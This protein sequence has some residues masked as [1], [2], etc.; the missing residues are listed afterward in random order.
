MV[1]D[2][3][4]PAARARKPPLNAGLAPHQADPPHVPQSDRASYR[5]PKRE[6][7]DAHLGL[8]LGGPLVNAAGG[9]VICKKQGRG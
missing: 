7:L 2:A 3:V 1:R 6:S 8:H 4:H 9:H 5:I